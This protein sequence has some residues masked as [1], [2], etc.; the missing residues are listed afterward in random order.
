MNLLR[1]VQPLEGAI[2]YNPKGYRVVE[3]NR[4]D[5]ELLDE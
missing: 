2:L 4:L 5:D 3:E 1:E